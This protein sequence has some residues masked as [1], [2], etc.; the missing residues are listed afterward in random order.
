MKKIA[1]ICFCTFCMAITCQVQA[2]L[3]S[4]IEQLGKVMY[5]DTDFSLNK[6]QSCQTC[7]HPVS[8][9]ADPT[10][11]RD[12]Y[13]TVVSLGD[14]GVSLGGRN[15]P[16]AAYAGSS[17]ILHQR[18]DG[19]Y[20]GGMFWDGRA[21]GWTLLDPLAEQAQGPPL[22][23]V[24][25]NMPDKEAVVRAVQESDYV[26]LFEVVFGSGSLKNIEEAYDYIAFAIAAY[27]RSSEIQQFSS[28][29]D[30]GMLSEKE[31][32]GL[33]VF[34]QKC[35]QCHTMNSGDELPVFTDYSYHNI[36]I[37]IN[38][39]LGGNSLD[40]GLGGFLATLENVEN[41]EMQN[42]KFKV[43]TLRNIGLTAPYGHNGYFATLRDIVQFK[44]SRDVSQW[45]L[46]EVNENVNGKDLG[47]LGMTDEEI[48]DLVAFLITLN[49]N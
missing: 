44:N 17:P 25:M 16:T 38:S 13:F 11:S 2:A 30:M 1:F 10:N 34:G 37:P 36:G 48:D 39:I 8:G 6:T 5:K 35:A 9:F 27:E 26:H 14:D 49:D 31:V 28:R 24:E 40:L 20:I 46:P 29:Y 18:E 42:G 32:R 19:E 21:T 15:A 3:L 23:P 41:A 22:N 12:P 45:P 33:N 7:H 47:N 4:K 43:P